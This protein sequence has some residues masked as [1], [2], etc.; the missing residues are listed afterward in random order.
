MKVLKHAHGHGGEYLLELDQEEAASL[1]VACHDAIELGVDN[2]SVVSTLLACINDCLGQPAATPPEP[3]LVILGPGGDYRW[4][5]PEHADELI[6][7]DAAAAI[8]EVL[9]QEA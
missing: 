9:P 1:A 6:G 5:W 4:N 8:A 3:P 7:G 2:W